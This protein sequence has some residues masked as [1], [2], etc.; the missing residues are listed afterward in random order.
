MGQG[1]QIKLINGTRYNWARTYQHSY[2]MNDWNLPQSIPAWSTATQYVEWDQGI[3]KTQS[4]DGAE[5]TY[6][7]EGCGR[8]FQVQARAKDG[9]TLLIAPLNLPNANPPHGEAI[10]L[11]WKHDGCVSFIVAG[12]E[13]FFFTSRSVGQWMQSG[14]ALLGEHTLRELC[15]PGSHDSGMSV[16]QS[17]TAFSNAEN[18]KTQTLGLLGQLNCGARYFDIRPVISGGQFKTGH[19]SEIDVKGVKS[20]QGS[21]GQSIPSI[22]NDV[23]TFTAS[24][25]ELVILYLSHDLNTDVGNASYS[26]LTQPDWDRLLSELG[27]LHNLYSAP[28][29]ATAD[30]TKL[31]LKDFIGGDRAAVVVIVDPSRDGISLGQHANKGFYTKNQFAIYNTYSNT[32]SVDFMV[33]DQLD[34]M[35]KQRTSPD[36]GVFLLSWTLTQDTGQS[37]VGALPGVVGSIAGFFDHGVNKS[38]L[39]LA[40]DAELALFD[41]LLPACTRT[42][43]PNI[44]YIDNFCTGDASA[45][46]WRSIARCS[47]DVR[48]GPVRPRPTGRQPPDQVLRRLAWNFLA[49]ASTTDFTARSTSSPVR[50]RSGW[51][52]VMPKWTLC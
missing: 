52:K 21:S 49:Q 46:P 8:N 5:A 45:W 33:K 16:I 28:A 13:G 27:G 47:A 37:V 39:D 7:F 25:K 43:Y 22:I 2:Q 51:R 48:S 4:D 42:C 36:S 3:F 14:F 41:H 17:S 34:K 1:G 9:F 35:H 29:T 32:N 26:A 44:I 50:V 12:Q 24:A 30:L 6:T 11:G 38:I 19:Y 20:W 15:L 40:S 18:T 10:N 23:N 31:K